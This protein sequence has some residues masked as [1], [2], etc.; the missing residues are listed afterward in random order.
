MM[1][2]GRPLTSVSV[3]KRVATLVGVEALGHAA[4]T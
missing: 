2:G 4:S 3:A 1:V